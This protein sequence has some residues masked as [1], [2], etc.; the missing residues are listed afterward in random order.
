M[1]GP[2]I[3]RRVAREKAAAD[4]NSTTRR[5]KFGFGGVEGY[6][7]RVFESSTLLRDIASL[8]GSVTIRIRVVVARSSKAAIVLDKESV[9]PK[10]W[11][12]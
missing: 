10:R 2:K 7:L 11:I 1:Q 12:V 3:K 9:R 6:R 5:G 8:A 4:Q